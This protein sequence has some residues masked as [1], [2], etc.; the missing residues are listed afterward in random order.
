MQFELR[1]CCVTLQV[2]KL[3][4]TFL[5][6]KLARRSIRAVQ[7][8]RKRG[9]LRVWRPRTVPGDAERIGCHLQGWE[10]PFVRRSLGQVP[11]AKGPP[12]PGVNKSGGRSGATLTVQEIISSTAGDFVHGPRFHL[13]PGFGHLRLD[14]RLLDGH[15]VAHRADPSPPP[16]GD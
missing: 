7:I 14:L 6:T 15:D 8:I 9:W 4:H 16:A 5:D 10:L 3:L 2:C 13:A 11:P 1:E 12:S